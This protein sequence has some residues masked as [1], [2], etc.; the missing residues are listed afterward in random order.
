[1]NRRVTHLGTS[2]RKRTGATKTLLYRTRRTFSTTQAHHATHYD[3][4]SIPRNASK[5]QIKSAYYKLSKTFHPDVNKEPQA[6]EKFLAFS[7]AY[8]VLG[9]DRQRADGPTTVLS[10]PQEADNNQVTIS[11]PYIL[12]LHDSERGSA[13]K[14][15]LCLGTPPSASRWLESTYAPSIP[16]P[17]QHHPRSQTS[18]SS[19]ASSDPRSRR[20]T[21]DGRPLY[22]PPRT[23]WEETEL[24]RVNRVSGLGRALQLVG[25]FVAVAVVGTLGKS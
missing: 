17:H 5:S 24:D 18:S 4:L 9:D 6:S 19:Y 2:L 7:E 3:T 10:P 11:H 14:R 16:T 8:A 20:A 1:M 22:R 23:R 12:A 15:E 25:L 21:G 13:S